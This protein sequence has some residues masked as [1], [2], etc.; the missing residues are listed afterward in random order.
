[1]GVHSHSGDDTAHVQYFKRSKGKACFLLFLK[2]QTA[3]QSGLG[4]GGLHGGIIT[5]Q[6]NMQNCR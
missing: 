1:M 3:V 6:C 5:L 2:L 4:N